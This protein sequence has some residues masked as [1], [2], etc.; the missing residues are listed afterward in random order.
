MK[1]QFKCDFHSHPLCHTYYPDYNNTNKDVV[2]SDKDKLCI[3]NYVNWC[4]DKRKLDVIAITDHDL[5]QSSLYARKYAKAKKL[6]IKIVTGAEC[7]IYICDEYSKLAFRNA[8]NYCH[9]LVLGV[10]KIPQHETHMTTD[11]FEIWANEI[12][13]LGGITVMSHPSFSKTV[14]YSIAEYLDGFEILNRDHF[15]FSEG[16]DYIKE[17]GLQLKAFKNSDFHYTD[18]YEY[19]QMPQNFNYED[20]NF[21]KKLIK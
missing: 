15:G 13:T 21:I 14:F 11:Q 20:E 2:L 17:N 5:I 19:Y 8:Y 9:I 3:E 7:E 16:L 18:D 6:P 12:K 10:D 1:K 4:V